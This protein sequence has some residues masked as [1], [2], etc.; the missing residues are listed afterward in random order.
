MTIQMKAI[1]QYFHVVL[2]VNNDLQGKKVLMLKSVI[3]TLVPNYFDKSLSNS[4]TNSYLLP[5]FPPFFS[6]VVLERQ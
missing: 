2:F 4:I 1:K 3:E 5:S 6:T